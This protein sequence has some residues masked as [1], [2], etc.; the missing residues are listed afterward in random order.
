MIGTLDMAGAGT[1][2][3]ICTIMFNS[4]ALHGFMQIAETVSA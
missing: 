1:V 2:S 3:A 4:R